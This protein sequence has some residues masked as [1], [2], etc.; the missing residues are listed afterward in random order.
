MIKDTCTDMHSAEIKPYSNDY[1]LKV[2]SL[3]SN[4]FF[5]KFL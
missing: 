1:E 4:V 2:M 3:C 5:Q